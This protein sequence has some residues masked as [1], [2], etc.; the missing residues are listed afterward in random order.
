MAHSNVFFFSPGHEQKKFFLF[1]FS[2]I[3]HKEKVILPISKSG[4]V[5]NWRKTFYCLLP[6][7]QRFFTCCT[8]KEDLFLLNFNRNLDLEFSHKNLQTFLASTS[9]V[10]THPLKPTT[11]LIACQKNF[12]QSEAFFLGAFFILGA[13]PFPQSCGRPF[14]NKLPLRKKDL[15]SL[16]KS[17]L[18]AR[19]NFRQKGRPV[20]LKEAGRKGCFKGQIKA[21]RLRKRE[22]RERENRNSGRRRRRKR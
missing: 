17:C 4:P 12:P 19:E 11:S 3:F 22:R 15:F 21:A 8:K 1:L 16:Q 9:F 14:F 6:L 18:L 2:S 13:R 10:L 7:H 20:V 5:P